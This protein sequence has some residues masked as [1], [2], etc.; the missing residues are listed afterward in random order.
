MA[1]LNVNNDLVRS[2]NTN[3]HDGQKGQMHVAAYGCVFLAPGA[4]RVVAQVVPATNG[5][6]V[7]A[8]AALKK[9]H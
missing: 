6:T 8:V 9:N 2:A 4:T 3:G 5:W 1:T 7:P